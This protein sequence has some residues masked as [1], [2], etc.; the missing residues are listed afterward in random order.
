MSQLGTHIGNK[1]TFVWFYM[2]ALGRGVE[3]TVRLYTRENTGYKH[4][5]IAGYTSF[6]HF[7]YVQWLETSPILNLGQPKSVIYNTLQ[8]HKVHVSS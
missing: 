1:C 2:L 8:L 3:K 6:S 5:W 7:H 4:K